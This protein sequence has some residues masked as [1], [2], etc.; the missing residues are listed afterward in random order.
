MLGPLRL[1]EI[2]RNSTEQL[3]NEL[4]YG[5]SLDEKRTKFSGQYNERTQSCEGICR[6]VF[7]QPN[8]HVFEG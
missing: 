8:S 2:T 7:A 5:K 1:L 3:Q 4:T 6:L